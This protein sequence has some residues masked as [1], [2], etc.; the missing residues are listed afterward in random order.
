MNFEDLQRQWATLD[1][2]LETSIRLNTEVL[3]QGKLEKTKSA[4]QRLSFFIWVEVLLT[5]PVVLVVGSFLANHWHEPAFFIPGLTLHVA[6]IGLMG[7]CIYQLVTLNQMDF[8][9]PV[10]TIQKRLETLRIH[11]IRATQWTFLLA[12]LL[13]TPLLIVV[14]RGLGVNAYATFDLT[15]M[16]AN[17]IFGLAVVVLG[18]WVSKRYGHRMAHIPW[19]QKLMN[20]LAGNNLNQALGVL[21]TLSDFENEST[22]K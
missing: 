20:D 11:R 6:A 17:F 18:I 22:G 13:W 12:P 9:A 5:I 2:K 1:K 3:R 14:F 8:S 21:S 10:L 4:L 15:W 7:S 19:I 16:A